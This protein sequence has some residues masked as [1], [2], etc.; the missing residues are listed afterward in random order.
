VTNVAGSV[1]VGRT[2]YN[3]S[4]PV[5]LPA[6]A[7]PGQWGVTLYPDNT[8]GDTFAQAFSGF[9]KTTGLQAT[10]LKVYFKSGQF[11][12]TLNTYTSFC[13]SPPAGHL[14]VRCCLC[15]L[16]A[17]DGS[18]FASLV[19]SL[20]ALKA[21]GLTNVA[22]TLHQECQNS[23]T[24]AQ[25]ISV[26]KQYRAAVTQVYG[27]V[28]YYDAAGSAGAAEWASYD[29]GGA[30]VD[31]YAIDFYDANGF[32]GQGGVAGDVL[33]PFINLAHKAGKPWGLWETGA[34]VNNET[35]SIPKTQAM[36]SYYAGKIAA[37]HKAG[38]PVDSVMWYWNPN[39]NPNNDPAPYVTQIQGLAA[40]VKAA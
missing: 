10:S 40:T 32:E 13:V 11:P 20:K 5:T 28:L 26:V 6:I 8:S 27:N 25:Y 16:P 4:S 1:T 3:V 33:Q 14:P 37:D 15:Y 29:P 12:T 31:G 35:A 30:W 23:L 21:L 24:A 38:L 18:D 22:V 9:E 34:S 36:I 7:P 2:S 19:T 17:T 39:H